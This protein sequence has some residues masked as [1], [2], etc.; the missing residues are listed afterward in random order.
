MERYSLEIENLKCGGCETSI[1]EALKKLA[2]I[3]AVS[4]EA[5]KNLVHVDYEAKVD[6]SSEAVD[7]KLAQMGYPKMGTGNS[8]QKAK[9]YVSCAIGKISNVQKE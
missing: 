8:F 1:K 9:S 4:I 3:K 7:K 5:D 2:G 6:F